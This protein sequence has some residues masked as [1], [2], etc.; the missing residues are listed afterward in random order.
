MKIRVLVVFVFILGC[1]LSITFKSSTRAQSQAFSKIAPL[2]LDQAR[3]GKQA[4]FLVVLSDQADLSGAE[5]LRTKAE[6]GRF[7]YNALWNKAQESQKDLLSWLVASKVEHRAYYIVN[8]I[9]V[10]GSLDVAFSL[11]ARNEVARIDANPQIKNDVEQPLV[12]TTESIEQVA[13]VEPG[14]MNTRATEV[15]SLG[16]TGQNIVVAG[17][18]TGYRFDHNAIK[19]KY[20][21]FTGGTPSHDFNWHDSIH[22]GGGVCGPNSPQPCDDNG[23]GTHTMGTVVGDDGAGN[24]V[25][26]A[27]GAKWIGCRNMD[28][29]NGTPA[30]YIECME[31]FLA[32][33]PVGGT[34][35]QGDPTKAPDVTSNS[36]TCPPSE[37]C[38]TATLQQAVEA[39]R[40]AGIMMVVAAGNA[41]PSCSTVV[42]PPSIYDAAYTVGAFDHLTGVIANFSSRGPVTIDGSNR[43]KPDIS[44]P[45]VNIRSSTRTTTTSYGNLSGTS[46]ATPHV[47]GAVALLWSAQPAITNNVGFAEQILN[48]AA[49]HVS[50]T[51]QCSVNGVPNNVYGNGRLDIKA[52]VDAALPC[53]SSPSLSKTVESFTA[54]GAASSVNVT[55]PGGCGWIAESNA[56]WIVIS[57]GSSGSGNGSVNYS[58]GANTATTPRSGI[59]TIG[60][61]SLTILQGAMFTDVPTDNQ[62]YTEIGKL[63]A[64]GITVGCGGGAF[65]PNNIVT[66]GEMAAF[67]IRA[68]GDFN[69]PLPAQQRFLD[70]PPQNTFYRF[71]DELAVRQITVGCGGGNYCVDAPVQR[72]QMAAFLIR[73]LGEFNPPMPPQQRFFDVT[74]SSPFYNFVDR[75]AVLQITNGC[76]GGNY[77]P[78]DSVTRAQ[79]AAFLVRAFNL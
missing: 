25:G 34:P 52:A 65:C 48:T 76:G 73:A 32:P 14:I 12:G 33:Y 43:L 9:S 72:D 49:V 26:M 45:G 40:A 50:V 44:A 78:Q 55:S 62:F 51:S 22:S 46:M 53:T 66:R 63:S 71:I 54:T 64:H 38:A 6:K 61:Q 35:A 28:Q 77:C 18:D 24:Q 7:V 29:G 57:S 67:I 21:G 60:G 37:G 68:L 70:V 19:A 4:E 58:I 42:D 23:H 56:G 15:W 30:T 47:A 5:A 1:L 69:P 17:A 13:G 36:W 11:A 59:L 8:M 20:R 31:F 79:M 75:L 74:S 10:K 41:G 2:M 3:D 27:P 39:Q 16:F